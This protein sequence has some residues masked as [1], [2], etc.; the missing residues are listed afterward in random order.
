M[1]HSDVQMS[2]PQL[3][4]Q[5]DHDKAATLGI[6]AEQVESALSSAYG[7][8]QISLIY[9]AND[10]FYVIL[11]LQPEYQRDPNALSMLYISTSNGTQVPLNTLAKI[12]QDVSPPLHQPRQSNSLCHYLIQP[13]TRYVLRGCNASTHSNG[14]DSFTSKCYRKLSGFGTSLQT[15]LQRF[16]IAVAR[17]DYRYLSDSGYPL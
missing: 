14:A 7:T 8:S 3:Q 10:Q 17:V 1:L 15:V 13:S 16:R 5:I 2:T 4:I 9:A 11:E 6:T 12:T